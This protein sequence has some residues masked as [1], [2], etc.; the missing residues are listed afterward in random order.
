MSR[1]GTA[2][3]LTIYE[4][5]AEDWWNPRS[6]Y[7]RSLQ[8]ISPLRVSMIADW[9][10]ELAGRSVID[11][12]CGG[13]LLSIPLLDRGA[14]VTG[15]DISPRS[16]S[17]ASKRA[18]GRGRFLTADIR[19]VPLA[20]ASADIVLLADVLD[21][22]PDYPRAIAEAK[23]LLRPGGKLFVSTINRTWRATLLAVWLGEG[24]RL[25]PPGTHDPKLFIRPDELRSAC[26][27][28]GL[29]ERQRSGE[30]VDVLRT[31]ARWA[32]TLRPSR[33]CSVAYA[34]LFQK[35]SV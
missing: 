33:D 7:F 19:S 5:H 24:L 9:C 12:G 18:A 21:H 8:N 31:V 3:D 11:L 1:V 4:N 22:L 32:I 25:I 14:Q 17:T 23:R 15:V 29:V 2:N 16:V 30:V 10:G 13:G 35:G 28:I 26:N 6:L 20:D 27:V 34:A